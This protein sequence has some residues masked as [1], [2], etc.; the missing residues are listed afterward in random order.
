MDD[1]GECK[2]EGDGVVA[3]PWT[4][5][6]DAVRSTPLRKL[7]YA[8]QANM[9]VYG[10]RA[11]SHPPDWDEGVLHVDSY[12]PR[13]RREGSGEA[14]ADTRAETADAEPAVC[15]AGVLRGWTR[16]AIRLP[17]EVEKPDFLTVLCE[18][19]ILCYKVNCRTRTW[20]ILSSV[21]NA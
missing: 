16:R 11:V 20:F 1:C 9:V 10:M 14:R 3:V 15:A 13:A 2:D 18:D 17:R 12:L 21:Q 19:A 5:W 7:P 8:I 6:R 4:A